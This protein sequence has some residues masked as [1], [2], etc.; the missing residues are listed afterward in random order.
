[1]TLPLW[2]S[3]CG[4]TAA[5]GAALIAACAVA[6]PERPETRRCPGPAAR[7]RALLRPIWS[8]GC[9]YDL[10]G[11]PPTSATGAG[12]VTCPECGRRVAPFDALEPA[13]IRWMRLGVIALGLGAI[14]WTIPVVK[15][16]QWVRYVP[17]PALALS[18]GAV[19]APAMRN[20][21]DRRLRDNELPQWAVPSAAAAL[22]R[23]LRDDDIRWNSIEAIHTLRRLGPEATGAL[24]SA[25][26]SDDQQQR[27]LAAALLRDIPSHPPS[28][29]LLEVTIEGLTTGARA[30]DEGAN[31]PIS[32]Q[33]SGIQY[34]ARLGPAAAEALEQGLRSSD[35]QA[36]FACA[37]AAGFGQIEPL[38]DLAAPTLL[39][40]LR[41][42]ELAGDARVAAPALLGFGAAARPWLEA[43]R[44]SPDPQQRDTVRLILLELDGPATTE[45]ERA[46]RAQLNRITAVRTD[47]LRATIDDLRWLW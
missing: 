1:M 27:L 46:R 22:A 4:W 40:H 41:D 11:L 38:V 32:L 18:A 5:F 39:D 33:R 16:G 2:I 8:G 14:G 9:G 45:A 31:T 43:Y 34:L 25:L 12:I 37:I 44:D 36:R 29:R 23:N 19:G 6:R 21:M 28:P 35:P 42:N 17:T 20:E 47:P 24:Q 26:D 7:W 13:G 10:R 15:T 3:I 30:W